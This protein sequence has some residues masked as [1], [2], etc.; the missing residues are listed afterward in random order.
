M[1]LSELWVL[2]LVREPCD[3]WV[4]RNTCCARTLTHVQTSVCLGV[5]ILPC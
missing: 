2:L 5:V 3:R 4:G 1:L